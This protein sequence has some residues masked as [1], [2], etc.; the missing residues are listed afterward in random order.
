[1]SAT[2]RPELNQRHYRDVLNAIAGQADVLSKM[3]FQCAERLE[4]HDE[5]MTLFGLSN[6]ADHIG[7]LADEA[8]GGIFRG[9]ILEWEV[10]GPCFDSKEGT[11]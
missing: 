11:S 8:S 3:A 5:A 10:G 6:L 9:G 7:A 2:K 1:M 4:S